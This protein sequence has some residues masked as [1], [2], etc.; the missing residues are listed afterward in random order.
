VEA[1]REA[2]E[3]LPVGNGAWEDIESPGRFAGA[4]EFLDDFS[5][6]HEMTV[7]QAG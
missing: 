6:V 2:V 1:I 7:I 3:V 4:A 5:Y